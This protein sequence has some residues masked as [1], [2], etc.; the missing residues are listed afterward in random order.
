MYNFNNFCSLDLFH[1]L[2]EYANEK[3]SRNVIFAEIA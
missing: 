2:A 3:S 1:V